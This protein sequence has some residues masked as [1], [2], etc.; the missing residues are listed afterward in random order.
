MRNIEIVKT[1]IFQ[2]KPNKTQEKIIL[3]LASFFRE[4]WE[5]LNRIHSE[6]IVNNKN[7]EHKIGKIVEK[8]SKVLGKELAAHVLRKNS[9]FW[10]N[11]KDKT[12]NASAYLTQP[13][14]ESYVFILSLS[15]ALYRF[16]RKHIILFSNMKIPF[17]GKIEKR[18]HVS[19]LNIFYD[20]YN[21]IWYAFEE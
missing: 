19:E 13:G 5:D 4:M 9:N 14:G 16:N 3:V 20:V 1:N 21:G 6:K 11:K 12:Q 10:K 7:I 2:I 18:K 8:Y 17:F 15:K